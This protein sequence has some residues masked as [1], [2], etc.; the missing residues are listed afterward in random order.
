MFS[1]LFHVKLLS[2]RNLHPAYVIA[3]GCHVSSSQ[4]IYAIHTLSFCLDIYR[5]QWAR[6]LLV[7]HRA[8]ISRVPR[9]DPRPRVPASIL[10]KVSKG[11]AAPRPVYKNRELRYFVCP[12][13][14]GLG[15]VGITNLPTTPL[16]PSLY[17]P[18]SLLNAASTISISEVEYFG[19]KP[20]FLPCDKA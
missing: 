13:V 3:R 17:S 14:L 1:L 11:Q 7:Y 5:G 8:T 2:T 10:S 4:P 18:W 16:G 19:R 9:Q 6:S 12:H 15:I 20:N